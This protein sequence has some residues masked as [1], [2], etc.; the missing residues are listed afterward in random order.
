MVT[1]PTLSFPPTVVNF[2]VYRGPT[3]A[4]L[5]RIA[6]NLP[7]ASSYTDVGATASL[8]GPPDPNYDHAN[9]YWRLEDQPEETVDIFSS[10][11]IGN[12]TL[13]MLPNEFT[14]DTV[15]ILNGTGSG[16][17]R[18]IAGNTATT[19]TITSPWSIQPDV[20]STFVVSDSSWQ[21]G[22]TG[23]TSPV[24][25]DVPNR[26]GVTVQI[27][28][29][30]ANVQ[31]DECNYQL[32][33]LTR[34]Q[35]QGDGG[36]LLDT[37]V[38]PVPSFG[39]TA[40]GQGS[41]EVSAISFST[42][43]D[44]QSVAAGTLT[45]GYWDE[46]DTPSSYSLATALDAVTTTIVLQAP[47]TVNEGDFI[48]IDAEVLVVA[49]SLSGGAMI[50]VTRAGYGTTAVPH[51]AGVAVYLLEKTTF[52]MAFARQFFGSPASGSY[53]YP[54]YLPDVRIATAELFMTNSIGNS[55]VQRISLTSLEDEGLRTL[56]GGQV[57]IQVEGILAI[58]TNA[59]PPLTMQETHSVRD[60]FAN[61][62]TAPTGSAIELQVTQNGQTFCGL[63]IAVGST[64][65]NLVDGF[66]LGPLTDGS[67]IGLDILSLTQ[68][69]S[70]IPGNNLTVTIRL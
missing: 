38:P 43:D 26:S 35:I 56:S 3:P 62:S 61:I 1:L 15:R 39:L 22:A 64:T 14:G 45:L 6:T 29:R 27:S 55:D 32:C 52:V 31:N 66:A 44:T 18:S 48:Q 2:D 42:F 23:P 49:A 13:G 19:V 9:F 46:L 34:W 37:D 5:F 58:Q 10:L 60:V 59:A 28:G 57:S 7:I 70:S 25:F 8:I 16:Q 40:V 54:A 65:S 21:F 63:T 68:T 69:S 30:S 24:T 12:S 53:A 67:L 20:T 17:E 41:V 50:Q 51:S 11:T 4:E 36:T 33:P 47:A